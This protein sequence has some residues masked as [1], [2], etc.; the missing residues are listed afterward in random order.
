[1]TITIVLV[2][3]GFLAM[4]VTALLR[5]ASIVAYF[6]TRELTVDGRNEVRAV[7]GGFGVAVAILLLA[8]LRWDALQAGIV[9]TVAVAL[10]GMAAGRLLSRVIDGAAGFYPWLFCAIELAAGM[11]LLLQVA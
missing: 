2:A 3:T 11:A 9:A 4:G 1:M 10:L 7:Y 6:G 8:S 5:P